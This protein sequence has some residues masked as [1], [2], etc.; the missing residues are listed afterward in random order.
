MKAAKIVARV[1]GCL[2]A[3]SG[4]L[5]G[6]YFTSVDSGWRAFWWV[7]LGAVGQGILDEAGKAA[8]ARKARR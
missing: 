1:V 7:W 6:V 3:L 5:I 4:P 8:T 2:V